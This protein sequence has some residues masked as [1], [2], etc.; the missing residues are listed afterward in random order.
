MS[1]IIKYK[2]SIQKHQDLPQ[3]KNEIY[4]FIL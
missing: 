4:T 3:V 2:M 1:K